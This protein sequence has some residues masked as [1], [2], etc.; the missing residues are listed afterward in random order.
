MGQIA[1]RLADRVIITND[2]PRRENPESIVNDILAG[3]SKGV[4]VTMDR[5]HAIRDAITSA[6]CRDIVLIAGKGHEDYQE[7]SGVR[8]PFN[9]AQEVR[10]ALALWR[11][12]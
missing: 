7:I 11:A 3:A 6:G 10:A 2:N 1:S 9:D 12:A 8:H 4:V 5:R